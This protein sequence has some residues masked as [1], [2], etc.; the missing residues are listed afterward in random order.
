MGFWRIKDYCPNP[1]DN[2]IQNW[3]DDQVEEVTIAFDWGMRAVAQTEDWKKSELRPLVVP[4]QGEFAGLYEVPVSVEVPYNK[5]ET[6]LLRP[7]GV[8]QP[9]SSDF[10]ILQVS[11][12][13]GDSYDPPL[14]DALELK[15]R[16]EAR[17]GKTY[18]REV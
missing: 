6:L 1:P 17:E 13:R 3:Y 8:W 18:D 10:V 14:S 15:A 4:L 16:W 7:I 2:P 5:K 9:D 12:R 11:V